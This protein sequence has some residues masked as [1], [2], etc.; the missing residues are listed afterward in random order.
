[1]TEPIWMASPPEVWSA[2]LSSGPGPGPLLA[3]AGMWGSLS[4]EYATVARELGSML[5][6]V[7]A[8]TWQGPSAESYIAA[9]V[10]YLAWLVQ[11]GA[12]SAAVASQQETAATAYTTAL[13]AMPT[14]AELAANHAI[15]AVLVATNF[16]GVN[17]I[18]IALNEA[19][20]IRMWLQAAL[21]MTT[22][23]T[24]STAAVAATPAAT[25]APPILAAQTTTP[26]HV[27]QH[28]QQPASQ[29]NESVNAQWFEGKIQ[30]AEQLLAQGDIQSFFTQVP[31]W[32]GE[33]ILGLAPG[34]SGIIE[35]L[36][37]IGGILAAPAGSTAGS[38]GLAG[39][40]GLGGLATLNTAPE[41]APLAPGA[42]QTPIFE[43]PPATVPP[44]QPATA[45][46][47][48]GPGTPV[49]APALGGVPP[50]ATPPTIPPVTGA[51]TAGFLYLVGVRGSE[52]RAESRA[53]G[54]AR[55]QRPDGAEAATGHTQDR[56]PARRR[57]R[58]RHA[59]LDRGFRY[60]YLGADSGPTGY[61]EPPSTGLATVSAPGAGRIGLAG[62]AGGAGAVTA[63]GLT[64]LADEPDTTSAMPM[65]PMVPHTWEVDENAT[66][67]ETSGTAD[68]LP[69]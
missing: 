58:R 61:P 37:G 62:T 35:N 28:H 2:L 51:E 16:F 41:P 36:G 34:L 46:V 60:E 32:A 12:N 24:V 39:L 54:R 64:A 66:S 53:A 48:A 9:N 3:A 38:A 5:A 25:T 68:D 31:H 67:D 26:Q 17:T 44:G 22:Y 63:A 49:T 42:T 69:D 29:D 6:A 18:P 59:V 13:A 15:H 27:H 52:A 23:Q 30:A 11:A 40:A 43:A 45:A 10:P 33:A 1:M 7:Q 55:A 21:T 14:M 57:P 65:A 8:G 20:Y 4:S 19:D 47:P 56:E 50:A